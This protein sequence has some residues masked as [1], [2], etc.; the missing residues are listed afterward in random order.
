M[1]HVFFQIFNHVLFSSK[2]LNTFPGKSPINMW[3]N[4][5]VQQNAKI[6]QRSQSFIVYSK[7]LSIAGEPPFE[8]GPFSEYALYELNIV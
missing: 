5:L 2:N 1:Y 7:P 4:L 8:C 6:H 3:T